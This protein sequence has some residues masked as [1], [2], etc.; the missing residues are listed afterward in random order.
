M[1]EPNMKAFDESDFKAE[2]YVKELVQECVGGA[3]LQQ[4]KSKIQ[5]YGEQTS[6]SLKKHVY[7]NYMQFIETAKEISHLESEMY[8]LS[9]LLIEQRNIL[10]TLRE[11]YSVDDTKGVLLNE[12][13]NDADK[14]EIQNKRALA[15]IQES[16]IGFTGNLENKTFLHEGA[17]IELDA[18]KYYRPICRVYFFLLNDLLIV[19]KVKHDKKLEYAA[20]YDAT[21]IAVINIKDLDG[22]KNA[23]NVITPDDSKIFQCISVTTKNEWIDKFEMALKF[24]QVKKKKAPAPKPPS[25]SARP[26]VVRKSTTKTSLASEATVSPTSTASE[27][28]IVNVRYAPE[29]VLSAHEEFHTL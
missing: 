25:H 18:E 24:N 8:Q 6:S 29:W 17:L 23:I 9:H 21:K 14:D 13:T 15:A 3:A 12:P 4:C 16:L 28:E 11:Q 20:Q 19:G 2:K 22:V 7:A 27:S 10:S 5:S 26:A 1:P